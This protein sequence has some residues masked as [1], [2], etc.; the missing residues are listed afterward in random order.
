MLW[1][2][3]LFSEYKLNF[4][5]QFKYSSV[6]KNCKWVNDDLM[7]IWTIVKNVIK[8]LASSWTIKRKYQIF[9]CETTV[10][11]VFVV[12]TAV[13]MIEE[14]LKLAKNLIYVIEGILLGLVSLIGIIGSSLAIRK[15]YTHGRSK[16]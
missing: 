7:H 12:Y 8:I 5:F 11:H 10:I 2:W 13:N 6:E 16:S 9:F 1:E 14:E 3:I 15:T 4:T